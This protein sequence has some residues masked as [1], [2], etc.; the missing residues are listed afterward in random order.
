MF[1][2]GKRR[3]GVKS[4]SG[5]RC[6]RN[7]GF[8]ENFFLNFLHETNIFFFLSTAQFI[9]LK[10]IKVKDKNKAAEMDKNLNFHGVCDCN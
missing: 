10:L 4:E 9:I 2:S 7:I 5:M 8:D 6:S 3:G 1:E